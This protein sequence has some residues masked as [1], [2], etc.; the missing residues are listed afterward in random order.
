MSKELLAPGGLTELSV[1][2]LYY[3]YVTIRPWGLPGA[4]YEC[5]QLASEALNV[6]NLSLVISQAS[7]DI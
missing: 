5:I 6:L 2:K 7:I 4:E 3:Y 1:I